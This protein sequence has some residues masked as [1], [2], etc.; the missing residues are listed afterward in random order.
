[1][2]LADIERLFAALGHRM[3]SGEPVTQLEHALQTAALAQEAGASA[4]LITACLLH[5]LGH[6]LN[7][8]GETPTLRGIDD[9]HQYVAI[10]RL[11][12]LF[13]EAVL[14]PI[15][16]HV[17]AKRYLCARGDGVLDGPAYCAAL[18]A[19]SKRSLALQGG[20]FDDAQAQ[21]FIEQ[22]YAADAVRLRR[23]DDAAKVAGRRTPSLS[24]FLDIAAGICTA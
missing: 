3:Y 4:E 19:D 6:L 21:A 20:V 14:A 7:D 24:H 9:R 11:R 18:S 2:T 23:W 13:S 17:D 1:M 22:P 5:D 15:R 10:P 16:L 8:Q 12:R